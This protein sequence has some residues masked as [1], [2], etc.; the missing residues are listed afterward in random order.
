MYIPN[1]FGN[2]DSDSESLGERIC[3]LDGYGDHGQGY[4]KQG[5]DDDSHQVW[6]NDNVVMDEN[7]K[8][9]HCDKDFSK[10]SKVTSP[11]QDKIISGPVQ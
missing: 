1:K 2:F 5:K 9:Q 7:I 6:W 3:K 10:K 4:S 11:K 8:Q